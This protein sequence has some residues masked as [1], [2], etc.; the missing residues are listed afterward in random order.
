[1]YKSTSVTK[2]I[3]KKPP[4]VIPI[5]VGLDDV[6]EE[7]FCLL[8]ADGVPLAIAFKTAGFSAKDKNCSA[9][10]LYRA[11][12]V[13]DRVT[14]IIK[15]RAS[16]PPVSLSEVTDML[17]RV[18][19]GAL[20]SGEFTPAHNAAFS[21]ARLYGL[22]VDRAQLDVI[23]RPSREPDAPAETALS[24]W[25]GALPPYTPAQPQVPS[26]PGQGPGLLIEAT[27][28]GSDLDGGMPI[29]GMPPRVPHVDVHRPEGLGEARGQTGNGAPTGPVTGTPYRGAHSAQIEN[30]SPSDDEG[31]GYP[32]AEE[33]F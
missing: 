25:I 1:M 20:H 7:C 24:A 2:R 23:R 4:V 6:R 5:G 32:S 15:A 22:V 21:L 12:R 11:Q 9:F 26:P 16:H 8:I 18:Y 28:Q 14:A 27:A 29:S 30:G 33:L 17:K 19:A 3:R 13:Q 10:D 31:T